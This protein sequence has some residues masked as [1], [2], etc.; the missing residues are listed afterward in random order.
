MADDTEKGKELLKQAVKS[1]IDGQRFYNF[2]A[3][4]TTNPDAKRKLTNLAGDEVRHEKALKDMYLKIYGEELTDIPKK[5]VGVLSK[6]FEHPE[7]HEK[8][9][10]RQY[11]DMAIEAELAATNYYKEQ[12]KT[13]PTEE[14]RQ[15]YDSMAAE[16]YR[17]FELL[18]AEKDA[19][20]GNYYWFSFGDTSPMED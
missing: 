5:G 10:E 3:D 14:F 18:Q 19:I 6:F 15:I 8:M 20:S 12:S 7:G 9:N 2:L 1:E 17:H 4:K 13:A 16:E 11:I